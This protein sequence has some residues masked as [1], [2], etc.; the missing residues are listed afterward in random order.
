MS[1]RDAPIISPLGPDDADS[2][3]HVTFAPDMDRLGGGELGDERNAD[4]RAMLHRRVLDAA[5]CAPKVITPE[6]R[7]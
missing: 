7:R 3:T 5:A 4:L 6:M 2:Y 1:I